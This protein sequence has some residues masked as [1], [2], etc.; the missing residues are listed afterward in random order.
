MYRLA[1]AAALALIAPAAPATVLLDEDFSHYTGAGLSPGG[2]AGTL[3]SSTWTIAG[4]SDGDSPHGAV[5]TAG[6]LARG[7]STGGVRAGGLYAFDL[8]GGARGLG[9]QATGSDFSPGTLTRRV[10]HTGGARLTDLALSFQLWLRNDGPRATR[11]TV[12]AADGANPAA[13]LAVPALSLVTP[14]TATGALW[15]SRTLAAALPV[16]TL[17]P[18]RWLSLRWRFEDA[19]GSGARDELA[20]TALRVTGLPVSITPAVTLAEP[21]TRGTGLAL[22]L[23]LAAAALHR[24]A[25]PIGNRAATRR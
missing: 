20:F 1:L 2:P 7:L 15:Q 22:A 3:D 18:G 13:W 16:D 19:S 10:Q 12:E 8:P 6:D 9:L 21:D 14:A 11:I 17:D 23:A 5:I 25:L 4:A 24:R